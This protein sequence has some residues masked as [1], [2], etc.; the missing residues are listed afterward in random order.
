MLQPARARRLGLRKARAP[1]ADARTAR[2]EADRKLREKQLEAAR[3]ETAWAAAAWHAQHPGQAAPGPLT[4]AD[5]TDDERRGLT[6]AALMLAGRASPEP[7]RQSPGE[8]PAR[9]HQVPGHT[10]R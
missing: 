10:R 4:V 1:A 6:V 2:E 7:P 9:R 8:G 5:M 3:L